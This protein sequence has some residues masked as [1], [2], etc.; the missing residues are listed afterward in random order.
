V[1]RS[2]EFPVKAD[3]VFG[4]TTDTAPADQGMRTL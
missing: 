4:Q 3:H 2:G 1:C